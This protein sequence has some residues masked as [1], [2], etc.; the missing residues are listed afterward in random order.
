MHVCIRE[1]HNAMLDRKDYEIF[2]TN[3]DLGRIAE[4]RDSVIID[5]ASEHE[6]WIAIWAYKNNLNTLFSVANSGNIRKFDALHTIVDET[7]KRAIDTGELEND[8][9][10]TSSDN[11]ANLYKLYSNFNVDKYEDLWFIYANN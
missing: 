2:I 11:R 6:R 4:G 7:I 3:S 10:V 1:K 5:E 8:I 9:I